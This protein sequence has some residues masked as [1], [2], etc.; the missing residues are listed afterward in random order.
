MSN[1]S[2]PIKVVNEVIIDL[3]ETKHHQERELLNING[4]LNSKDQLIIADHNKHSIFIFTEEIEFLLKK[5]RDR[6]R[7]RLEQTNA[8]LNLY[9]E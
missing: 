4:L 7:R 6:A 2:T 5:K 9:K 8:K 1:K 3:L